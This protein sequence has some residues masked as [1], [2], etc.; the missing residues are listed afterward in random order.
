VALFYLPYVEEAIALE[1]GIRVICLERPRDEVVASFC[2]WG[3]TVHPLP[4]DHWAAAPA[5]GW[6]HDPIWTRI[7]PQYLDTVGREEGI[8][9]YWDEYHTKASDLARRYPSSVRVIPTGMLNTEAG[10]REILTFAG[11]PTDRHAL[12]SR[13]QAAATETTPPHPR[14]KTLAEAG[15]NDPRRCAVLVPFSDRVSAECEAG[16][17]GLERRGYPVIRMGGHGPADDRRSLMATEALAYGFEETMWIDP[18][19]AFDADAV[20]RLRSHQKP[21]VC[22]VYAR[23]GDRGLSCKSLPGTPALQFGVGGGLVEVSHASAGF[24]LIRHRVYTDLARKLR[25]PLCDELSGRPLIPF[26]RPAVVPQDDG[27]SY[28]SGDFS[29]CESA[30]RCGYR[31]LADTAIRL[32]Y[33]GPYEYGWE[34]AGGPPPRH[35]EFTFRLAF[36][37]PSSA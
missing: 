14:R 20:D 27:A 7:F 33:H 34:D 19:I 22:G 11:F 37:G 15:P 2:K 26:F 29:F 3:D 13:L 25:L 1:P 36:P 23:P 9:R 6:F 21:V 30:R 17:R 4:T 28:L 8:R 24:M 12:H 18:D 31:V 32:W 5:E 35:P 16:L 10:V